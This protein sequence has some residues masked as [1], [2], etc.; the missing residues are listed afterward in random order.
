MV[1]RASGIAAKAFIC[2]I[3]GKKTGCQPLGC[4][5]KMRPQMSQ[6]TL[7]G[8]SGGAASAERHSSA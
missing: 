3:C 8:S 1:K 7:M 5:K 6:I 4:S 2:A